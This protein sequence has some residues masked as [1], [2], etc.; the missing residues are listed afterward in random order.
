MITTPRPT[1]QVVPGPTRE[2]VRRH[3]IL[4]H[5]GRGRAMKA[6]TSALASSMNGPLLRNRSAR[7]AR[8][9]Q[10]ASKVSARLGRRWCGTLRRPRSSGFE[11]VGEQVWAN[12][13]RQRWYPARWKG[14][15]ALSVARKM[16]PLV[17]VSESQFGPRAAEIRTDGSSRVREAGL[18]RLRQASPR[19][20]AETE[21]G[22]TMLDR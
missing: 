1:R 3:Q 20:H 4:V 11:D 18:H 14:R 7:W 21:P 17:A 15:S 19:P 9:L 16:S 8:T 13:T 10:V 5:W 22:T 6:R 12:W 2:V